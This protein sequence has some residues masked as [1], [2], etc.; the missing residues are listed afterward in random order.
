LVAKYRERYADVGYSEN[1]LYPGI[2]GALA[3][4]AQSGSRL[5]VCTSKRIDFAEKVLSM[6]HLRSHFHFVIGGDVGVSKTTQLKNLLTEGLATPGSTMIGDRAIDILAGKSNSLRSI[7]VLWGHGS[8][9]ELV[10]VGA[11]QVL[12][13]PLELG[14][15]G[16]AA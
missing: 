12:S 10:A 8:Q 1:T 3:K 6:F 11:D 15:L 9:A 16:Y 14:G 7:G 2:D 13:D 5:G 4:L